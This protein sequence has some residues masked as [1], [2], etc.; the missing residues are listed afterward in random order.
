MFV[1]YARVTGRLLP[2]AAEL[3]VVPFCLIAGD[4]AKLVPKL[5]VDAQVLAP[6]V[7]VQPA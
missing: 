7:I 5:T 6:E 2:F 1:P 3:I 4:G